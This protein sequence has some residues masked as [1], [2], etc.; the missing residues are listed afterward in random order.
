MKDIS[1]TFWGMMKVINIPNMFREAT[2]EKI[3]PEGKFIFSFINK[4]LDS[5]SNGRRLEKNGIC[6][7]GV[8]RAGKTHT[9]YGIQKYVDSMKGVPKVAVIA[10]KKIINAIK[11][12]FKFDSEFDSELEKL[13]KREAV[14]FLEDI[15]VYPG[16]VIID[17]IGTEKF[18]EAIISEYHEIINE[19][20]QQLRSTSFTTNHNPTSLTEAVGSRIFSRINSMCEL[21]EFKNAYQGI[22]NIPENK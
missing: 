10:S 21:V 18:T 3:T 9:V 19:R 20:Y 12:S 15:K 4:L 16:F 14:D 6:L 8:S 1:Q 22:N 17:D 2:L 7:F 13:Q 11:L 5:Y